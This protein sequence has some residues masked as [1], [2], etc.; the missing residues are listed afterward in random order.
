MHVIG[1]MMSFAYERMQYLTVAK[2]QHH[3][4]S[5]LNRA[6]HK[7]NT[8]DIAQKYI[9]GYFVEMCIG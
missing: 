6:A 2:I 1:L 9:I 7:Q 4:L 8:Q 5:T 3:S